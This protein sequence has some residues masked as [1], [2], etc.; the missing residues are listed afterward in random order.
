MAILDFESFFSSVRWLTF[1]QR[2]L[3]L[4]KQCLDEQEMCLGQI[5]AGFIFQPL[6]IVS[7]QF[8]CHHQSVVLMTMYEFMNRREARD[9]N[10][11]FSERKLHNLSAAAGR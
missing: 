9:L 4:S 6:K 8:S 2:V 5:H 1:T 10:I 3:A 11:F 7:L